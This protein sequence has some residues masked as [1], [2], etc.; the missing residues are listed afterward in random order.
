[1]GSHLESL[2]A[3]VNPTANKRLFCLLLFLF[4]NLCHLDNMSLGRRVPSVF[5]KLAVDTIECL[6]AVI[7]HITK[8]GRIYKTELCHRVEVWALVNFAVQNIVYSNDFLDIPLFVAL[9][10]KILYDFKECIPVILIVQLLHLIP[11]I[12]R[13]G[14]K[15]RT[16]EI[17]NY[18]ILS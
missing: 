4:H 5:S 10:C 3:T 7:L 14:I 11:K 2:R 1:M 16:F 18:I 12:D 9:M 13:I 8:T 6:N 17:L 15:R